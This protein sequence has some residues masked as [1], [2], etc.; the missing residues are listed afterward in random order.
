MSFGNAI[1]ILLCL[2]RKMALNDF[3]VIGA[4]AATAYLEPMTTEDLDMIVLVETDKDY[5]E[6][7]RRVQKVADRTE[8]M[9]L[10]LSGVPVQMFPTTTKPLYRDTLENARTFN[11]D[12][13]NVKVASPEHLV[14]LALEANRYKDKVR[15]QY[16]LPEANIEYL[17]ELL[18]VFDD[19]KGTLEERLE[20][21]P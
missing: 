14:V 12:G 19:E 18:E 13:I 2:K 6:V 7:F 20:E 1:Q 10:V 17:K 3:V 5:I 4:V 8:G 15:I 21:I 16:L 9:H 11:I